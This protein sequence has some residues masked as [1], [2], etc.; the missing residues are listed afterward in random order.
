MKIALYAK[1]LQDCFKQIMGIC[2]RPL[3]QTSLIIVYWSNGQM[4]KN[5]HTI[6]MLKMNNIQ[7]SNYRAI[8]YCWC[9][10]N[11]LTNK[12]IDHLT[13]SLLP[14]NLGLQANS[15]RPG[16]LLPLPKLIRPFA[17]LVQVLG[18]DKAFPQF[19]KL[20]GGQPGKDGM[21]RIRADPKSSGN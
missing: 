12:R 11:H 6:S 8:L 13:R 1:P 18:L 4:V 2:A 21:N 19:F 14:G 20:L 5:T 7:V 16:R 17:D 3:L 9:Y 10:K 15:L